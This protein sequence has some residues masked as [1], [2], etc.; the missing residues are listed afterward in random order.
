MPHFREAIRLDP[1]NAQAHYELAEALRDEGIAQRD[2]ALLSEAIANYRMALET[3][4]NDV[5]ARTN[6]GIT[7][8]ACNQSEEALDQFRRVLA[9]RPDWAEA[10][11]GLAL[12]YGQTGRF[13]EALAAAQKALKLAE[14]QQKKDLIES[15]RP[16]P[17]L[18]SREGWLGIGD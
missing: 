9:I 8:V 14:Q 2:G 11:G 17:A 5:A 16:N 4:P 6:L 3:N 13:P 1:K 7:L 15:L 12:A 18:S 10:Q